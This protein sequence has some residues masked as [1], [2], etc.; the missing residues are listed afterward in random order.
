M[1]FRTRAE[2]EESKGLTG[3][4]SRNSIRLFPGFPAD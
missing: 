2:A 1:Y 4:E 3:R